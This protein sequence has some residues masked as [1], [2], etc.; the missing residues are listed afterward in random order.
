MGPSHFLMRRTGVILLAALALLWAAAVFAQAGVTLNEPVRGE[1]TPGE[2]QTY[3]FSGKSGQVISALAASAGTL[4]PVLTLLDAEGVPI[5]SDDDFAFPESNDALLQAVTLPYTGRYTLQ[6]SGWGDSAGQY[7]LTVSEGY[8]VVETADGFALGADWAALS[9]ELQAD[10]SDGTL[11]MSL[12]GERAAGAA[13]GQSVDSADMAAFVDVQTVRNPSGWITGLALRRS[14]NSYYALE[15]NSEGRWRFVLVQDGEQTVVRDWTGHPAIIAGETSFR[16]GVFAKGSAFDVFYDGAF[17]GATSDDTLAEAGDAGV[18]IGTLSSLENETRATFAHLAVTRPLLVDGQMPIPQQVVV[19]DGP[20]MAQSLARRHVVQ[21]DGQMVLTV[22]E[23]SVTYVRPGVN[24][25]MLGQNTQFADFAFG[26]TVTL[27]QIQAGPSGCGLVLR[28]SDETEYA[29]AWLDGEGAFGLS[30]KQGEVFAPGL[31][32][33]NPMLD[34]TEPHHLLVI[35][36]DHILHYYV[37]G[38]SAGQLEVPLT[39]GQVG[40][41]V[42]NFEGIETACTF[43]NLWLWRWE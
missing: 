7:T 40:A 26:G 37:D 15:I 43:N 24:R 22:P 21:G 6:V 20:T 12:R 5:L 11:S 42:V 9:G 36:S 23:A 10:L 35:A 8:A 27:K 32:G 17:I 31:F 2:A 3:A 1:V 39:E 33:E 34:P 13:F 25:L 16:M 30:V 18:L 41:A 28:Y 38:M 19:A 29:I 4:D 14:G